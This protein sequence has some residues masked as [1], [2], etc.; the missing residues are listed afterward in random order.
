MTRLTQLSLLMLL[1][2][3]G[4]LITHAYAETHSQ[5]ED[6]LKQSAE[7]DIARISITASPFKTQTATSH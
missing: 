6:K 3:N 2:Q 4:S 5:N 1:V 7:R